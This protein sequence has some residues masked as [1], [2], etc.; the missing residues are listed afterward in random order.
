ME[1]K[2]VRQEAEDMVAGVDPSLHPLAADLAAELLWQRGKLERARATIDSGG[3]QMVVPYDNGGGQKGIRKN[4]LFE[5]YNAAF[6]NYASGIN[7]LD[8]MLAGGKSEKVKKAGK[9]AQL[10]LVNGG[11]DQKSRA[12]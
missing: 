4:P 10:R 9:L 11:A 5:M 3:M 6:K 7:A 8:A 2:T 12:G 1:Y